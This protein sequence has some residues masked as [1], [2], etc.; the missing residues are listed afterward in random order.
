MALEGIRLAIANIPDGVTRDALNQ[1]ASHLEGYNSHT[2]VCAETGAV[3][4]CPT[5][6]SPGKSVPEGS[7]SAFPV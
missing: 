6:L 3:S 7:E 2:H 1:I 5:T 4:S